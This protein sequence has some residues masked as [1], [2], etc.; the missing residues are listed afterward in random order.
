MSVLASLYFEG[1]GR[2]SSFSYRDLIRFQSDLDLICKHIG[3]MPISSFCLDSMAIDIESH[4]P[5]DYLDDEDADLDTID[6]LESEVE[7]RIGSW[8]DLSSGIASIQA[9]IKEIKGIREV[10]DYSLNLSE[11]IAEMLPTLEEFEQ[12]M[13]SMKEEVSRFRVVYS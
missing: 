9:L 2:I 7:N 8:F 10:N 12:E 13:I 6:A 5:E 11:D 1:I 3:A 4:L